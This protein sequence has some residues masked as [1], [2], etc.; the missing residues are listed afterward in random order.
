[1]PWRERALKALAYAFVLVMMLRFVIF[2]YAGGAN[3]FGYQTLQ[4]TV[5]CAIIAALC[6]AVIR[7]R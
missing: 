7:L 3:W 2:P 5:I 1:M 4:L 6:R